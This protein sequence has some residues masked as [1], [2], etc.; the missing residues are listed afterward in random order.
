MCLAL[1]CFFL[2]AA[3]VAFGRSRARGWMG[4]AAARLYHSH[5]NTGS[6]PHLQPTTQLLATPDPKPT[7]QGQGLNL[8]HQW[9][10][11]TVLNLLSHNG[12]ACMCLTG[13][14]S[15]LVTKYCI[16][17][18]IVVIIRIFLGSRI[19][20]KFYFL[21]CAFLYSPNFNKHITQFFFRFQ[22]I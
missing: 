21:L 4:A 10:L 2:R 14:C 8:H 15:I 7:E 12:K 5:S 11:V 3:P 9:I 6:E 22:S 13:T 18:T 1:F 20:L 16:L 17:D 19:C